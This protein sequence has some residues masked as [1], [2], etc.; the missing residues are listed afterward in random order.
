MPELALLALAGLAHAASFSLPDGAPTWLAPLLAVAALGALFHRALRAP[1]WRRAAAIGFAFGL[2][3]FGAGVWWTYVSM[4]GHG[5]LWGPLAA[6]ASALLIALLALFPALALALATALAGRSARAAAAGAN[7]GARASLAR[8]ALLAACWTLGEWLRVV[9]L[10]GFPW[11]A[12]GLAHVEGPLAGFAPVLGELGVGL[13]AAA[14][15]ASI[16]IGIDPGQAGPGTGWR[17]GRRARA[18][19]A[20]LAGAILLGGS[21]LRL[22]SWSTP[23][24]APLPVRL[25]QGNIPQD[26][27]FGDDGLA[28]SLDAYEG[29]TAM[30]AAAGPGLVILPESAFP[31]PWGE[32]PARGTRILD[33]LRAQGNAVLF[34]AFVTEPGKRIFNSAIGL[35]ARAGAPMQ[36]YRKSHLVPFGEFIPAGLHWFTALLDIPIGDQDAGPAEQAPMA[37][38]GHEVAVNICFEQIFGAERTGSWR[39]GHA[40]G[41]L[42]NL[43]NL[44]WFDDSEALP[45]FLRSSRMRAIETARPMLLATNTGPTAILDEQGAVRFRLDGQR[46]GVLAAPVQ[47]MAGTTPFV[48]LADTPVLGSCA[49]VLALALLRARRARAQEPRQ[50][51]LRPREREL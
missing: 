46:A 48:R 3:W 34:G 36:V 29:L 47:A 22:V 24:G 49:A 39:D 50:R 13:A 30:A 28:L 41:I 2:G 23:Q 8:V 26:L 11:I 12:T 31:V 7:A 16:A 1:S 35:D 5:G 33:S 10:G 42:V 18:A 17:A 27:K 20:L 19:C 25:V 51:Q 9:V 43:S 44:A 37:L 40:P 21:A 14:L 45:Q 32:L 4:H 6:L 38:A 15:C